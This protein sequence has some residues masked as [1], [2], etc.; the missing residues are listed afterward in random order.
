M[1]IRVSV[2]DS[3]PDYSSVHISVKD[4]LPRRGCNRD[5]VA[6]SVPQWSNTYN[7]CR[8]RSR[9]YTYIS[10]IFIPSHTPHTCIYLHVQRCEF[11]GLKHTEYYRL[12]QT[13]FLHIHADT[14]IYLLP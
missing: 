10:N 8:D 2:L 7:T 4:I 3:Y 5:V 12:K 13:S 11:E 9:T 1:Y 6:V 14:Y